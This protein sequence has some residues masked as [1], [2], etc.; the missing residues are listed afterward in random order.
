MTLDLANENSPT[1][2]PTSMDTM[3]KNTQTAVLKFGIRS[4]ATMNI[5]KVPKS[6]HEKT[7][8]ATSEN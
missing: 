4:K 5:T 3:V 6:R 8:Q 7:D 1:K 2:M